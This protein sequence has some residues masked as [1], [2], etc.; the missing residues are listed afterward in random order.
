MSPPPAPLPSD[1]ESADELASSCL[2]TIGS[3]IA[4]KELSPL[5]RDY[6]AIDVRSG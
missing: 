1:E 2:L 4:D 6:L 5:L 3:F